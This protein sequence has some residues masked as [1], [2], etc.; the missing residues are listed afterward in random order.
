MML[1]IMRDHSID[2][3]DEHNTVRGFT[4]IDEYSSEF[5]DSRL[6]IFLLFVEPPMNP[7]QNNK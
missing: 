4:L 7:T 3:Y 1:V 6:E 5:S 2:M